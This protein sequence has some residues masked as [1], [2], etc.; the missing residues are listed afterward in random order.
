MY[1]LCCKDR[2]R[3][4]DSVE[5]NGINMSELSTITDENHV[6]VTTRSQ[7][8]GD[9]TLPLPRYAKT[10]NSCYFLGP[11]LW[12]QPTREIRSAENLDSFTRK[13]KGKIPF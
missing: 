10:R 3:N 7:Y 4:Y 1:I 5:T 2:H 6:G 11:S 9:I 8:Y 13:L 12:L